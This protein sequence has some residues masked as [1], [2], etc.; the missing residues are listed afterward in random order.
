MIRIMIFYERDLHP[1]SVVGP[2]RDSKL[3][4]YR[5]SESSFSN[6][7]GVYNTCENFWSEHA[8]EPGELSL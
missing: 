4:L 5:Y 3:C 2:S 6:E 1:Q 8:S 7:K